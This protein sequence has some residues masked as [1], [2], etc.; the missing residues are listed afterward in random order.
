MIGVGVPGADAGSIADLN[1]AFTAGV[2]G[3]SKPLIKTAILRGAV[4]VVD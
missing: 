4:M 1:E 3:D 2:Y